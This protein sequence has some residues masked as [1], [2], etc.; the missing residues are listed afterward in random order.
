MQGSF[1]KHHRNPYYNSAPVLI[2]QLCRFSNQGGQPIEDANFF[3]CTQSEWNKHLVVPITVED[4]VSFTNKY[5]LIATI[6]HSG[7]L[8]RGH[9][10]AFI[11]DLHSSSWYSCNDKLVFNVEERSL[12]NTTSYIL[13]Y[14]KVW[15]FPRIYQKKKLSFFF[16]F[17]KGVLSFQTLSLGVTTPHI[18][19]VLYGNWVCSLNFQALQPCSP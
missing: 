6:N 7:T 8:N 1:W 10:W 11:K 16:L 19:P 12:N 15:M 2:I 9:Y 18:T 17:C 4:E 5:S 3:S 14:R 13:F